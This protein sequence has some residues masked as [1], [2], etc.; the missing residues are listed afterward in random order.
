M[1]ESWIA[2]S[3][4]AIRDRHEERALTPLPASGPYV[5][6]DGR[7]YLNLAS[8][9]YLGLA[10]H[11]TVVE[12]AV[13]ACRSSGVGATAS[14]LVTGDLD[15][16]HT[17]ESHLAT[18]KQCETALLFGSGYLTSIGTIPVLAGRHDLV[19]IDRLAH[20]CLLDGA[21]L[22][23]AEVRRF[24][25][26]DV[27]HLSE[28]LAKRRVDRRCLIVTESVFSMDGD[29][30]PLSTIAALAAD[31]GAALLVDEAHAAG[32]FGPAGGGLTCDPAIRP[33]VTV[34][35]GTLSKALGGYGGYAACSSALRELLLNRARSFVFSTALPPP[36]LAAALAALTVLR[37]DPGIGARL[38]DTAARFRAVLSRA[39]L[40]TMQSAS[41]IVP[42]A[43]GNNARVLDIAARLRSAGILVAAIRPPTVPQGSARLRISLSAAHD[44]GDLDRAAGL[45]VEAVQA[46]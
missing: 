9:D 13:A 45:I 36:V 44:A 32:I 4:D 27:K 30:A 38:L 42:V 24:R 39:Q 31:S 41:H 12:A 23:G 8:N 18:F 26:N 34:A 20:A 40:D 43:V 10:H 11:P 1:P 5:E 3:R 6:Q 37:S 25:H 16:H 29:L 22:S 14:R 2:E 15:L 33:H 35:M 7:R 19:L 28:L 46:S 17:L 21:R